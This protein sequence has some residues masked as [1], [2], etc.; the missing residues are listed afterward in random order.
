MPNGEYGVNC[1]SCKTFI[2]LNSYSDYR[3]EFAPANDVI[4][5]LRCPACADVVTY[6]KSDVVFRDDDASA[7]TA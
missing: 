4:E 6:H 3:P 1:A 5:N 7:A 2:R